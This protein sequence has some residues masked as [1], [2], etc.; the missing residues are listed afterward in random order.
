MRI[1][2]CSGY[3]PDRIRFAKQAGFDGLEIGVH[4]GSAL[5]PATC[6]ADDLKLARS[7]LEENGIAALT[8]FHYEHY[9]H[10]KP[11]KREQARKNFKRS[12]AMAKAL[13][14]NIVTVNA[15]VDP[16]ADLKGKFASYK[17]TFSRFA[18][19]A[20]DAGIKVAI[21]NCP[22]GFQNIAWSPANWERMFDLVPSK[23]IGLEYD[24]SHLVWQGV[25]YV[26]AIRDFGGR[27]YAFHAKDTEVHSDVLA[28]Q[29]I[30]GEGWWRFRLP[31]L[32]DV[33]WKAVF[34]ALYDVNYKGDIIIEH[35]DPVFS[36]KRTDDGLRLGLKYLRGFTL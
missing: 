36:G 25:D 1:G 34:T 31:G 13:G 21:E 26:A 35:E 29:G 7:V 33:D 5:D 8:L 28:R 11:A 10:P 18:K 22:H 30:H 12:L 19:Q 2:F 9:A 24:P 6:T 15:W 17:E 16:S 3:N 4:P 20:E 32:G 27:I 23:A 14:T